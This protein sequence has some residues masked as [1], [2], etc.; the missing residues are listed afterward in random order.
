MNWGIDVLIYGLVCSV[1][2]GVA[3]FCTGYNEARA[4]KEGKRK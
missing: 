4:E 2:A 1:A 3:G